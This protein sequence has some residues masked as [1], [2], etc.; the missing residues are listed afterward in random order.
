MVKTYTVQLSSQLAYQ[1]YAGWQTSRAYWIDNG[2]VLVGATGLKVL[3]QRLF[4]GQNLPV[5]CTQ[6]NPTSSLPGYSQQPRQ[7]NISVQSGDVYQGTRNKKAFWFSGIRYA[8]FPGR[9]NYSSVYK[10]TGSTVDAQL[11]G[12]ECSQ[13]GAGSEDCL[14][15]NVETPYIPRRGSKNNLRPV[16]FWIHGGGFTGGNGCHRVTTF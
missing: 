14:F 3:D 13:S 2:V 6:S 9:F 11:Y 7:Y 1:S 8:A 12:S 16:L 10:G 4:F 5:L 15:L